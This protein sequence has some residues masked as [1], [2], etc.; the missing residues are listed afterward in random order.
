MKVKEL[1]KRL[2]ECDPELEVAYEHCYVDYCVQKDVEGI[3]EMGDLRPFGYSRWIPLEKREPDDSE[4]PCLIAVKN[5]D[6]SWDYGMSNQLHMGLGTAAKRG[7]LWMP[8]EKT[9]DDKCKRMGLD[10]ETIKRLLEIG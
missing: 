4:L 6:G 10:D 7:A 5:P 8:I 2:L 3:V 1:V 9:F